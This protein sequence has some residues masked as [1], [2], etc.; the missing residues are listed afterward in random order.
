MA[1]NG[2]GGRNTVERMG[3]MEWGAAK[4]PAGW[5][6]KET[7]GTVWDDEKE[8]EEIKREGMV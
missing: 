5:A 6:R 8:R 4:W 1:G 7:D 3:G 2:S